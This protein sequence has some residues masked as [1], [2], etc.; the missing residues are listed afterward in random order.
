MG[1]PKP[2]QN[3]INVDPL[4]FAARTEPAHGMVAECVYERIED[5][6]GSSS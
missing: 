5:G 3:T 4:K 2:C 6:N 1:N